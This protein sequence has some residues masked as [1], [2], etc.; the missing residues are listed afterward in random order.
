MDAS[1]PKRSWLSFC[2]Q[3]QRQHHKGTSPL[4]ELGID[5]IKCVP[6]DYMHLVCLGVVRTMI[7]QHW[8][9]SKP[10]PAKLASVT[11]ELISSKL[12]ALKSFVPTEFARKPREL[13]MIH[14]W[15]ATEFR[16]FLLYTGPVV[17][18]KCLTHEM[19]THFLHLSCSI[20]I[21]VSPTL[22]ISLLKTPERLLR[23]FVSSAVHMYGRGFYVM[24]VHCLLH[25]A[26]D[27]KSFGNL[28]NFSAFVFE[29]YLQHL[30]RLLRGTYLPLQQLQ[31]RLAEMNSAAL[32][33]SKV[34]DVKTYALKQKQNNGPLPLGL[35]CFG[36]HRVIEF[37]KFSVSL[38][39]ADCILRMKDGS[40]VKVVNIVD[41]DGGAVFVSCA[42][43]KLG[44]FFESPI[45]SSELHIYCVSDMDKESLKTWPASSVQQKM[46]M[47][48][49]D[50]LRYVVL[51]LYHLT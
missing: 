10:Q 44:N 28:D 1:A 9:S 25:L 36:M 23:E 4:V 5:L 41:S 14:Y 46:V 30:K 26:G 8:M 18:Y 20:Q 27:V 40:I 35:K 22:S 39:C 17:L 13:K 43:R 11:K 34:Q 21:L 38:S 29:D 48:P 16:Q 6:Y 31:N 51:P 37:A 32:K 33:G 50:S 7:M 47:F 49:I 42:F 24:N 2:N 19:Y 15:K 45:V 3:V 12:L